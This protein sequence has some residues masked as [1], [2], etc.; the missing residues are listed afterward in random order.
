M[1][2]LGIE[3]S[4]DDTGIAIYD[5]ERGLLFHRVFN[6]NALHNIHGGIVPEIAARK[7]VQNIVLLFKNMLVKNNFFN[8]INYI[9]YTAGPGLASSLLVGSTFAHA[10][11]MCLNIPVIPINH[12][13]AHLLS[14]MLECKSIKFP[15]IA[16]LASGK[17]TQIVFASKLGSYE[18][19]GR[20]LDDAAGEAFDKIAKL[21]G[22]SYPGGIELSKLARK[23]IKNRFCFPRP[24][25]RH[26]NLDFSFS[27][28]KTFATNIIKQYDKNMQEKANIAR[29]FEDAVVDILLIKIKKAL[30]QKKQKRLIIAGGVSANAMLRKKAKLMMEKH[31]N[32]E[33]FYVRPEFC[34]DNAAMIAYVGFLRHKKAESINQLKILVKPKWSISELFF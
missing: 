11:G 2:I 6:Q 25:I 12:M 10:L 29:A 19:L 15:F 20:S 22:L 7:H 8:K 26:A 4:C 17:H 34:T 28:L 30:Q 5:S 23:G 13:E 31:F 24:M 3:T 27:G 9:S 32:G 33:V 14:P 1:K 18:L 16:L 21:L